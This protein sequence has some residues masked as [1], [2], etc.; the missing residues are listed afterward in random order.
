MIYDADSPTPGGTADSDW[1]YVTCTTLAC[2]GSCGISRDY[3]LMMQKAE[4]HAAMMRFL[5]ARVKGLSVQWW[6]VRGTASR[7]PDGPWVR[8]RQVLSGFRD[9]NRGRHWDRKRR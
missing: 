3:E 4:R 2:I 1:P 5:G 8:T 9:S 6:T 7:A